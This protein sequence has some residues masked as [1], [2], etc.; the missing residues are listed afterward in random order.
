M[1][2]ARG[3]RI[4]EGS[5]GNPYFGSP[6][7]SVVWQQRPANLEAAFLCCEHKGLPIHHDGFR[8]TVTCF[9]KPADEIKLSTLRRAHRC[10]LQAIDFAQ[11]V[12]IT[13]SRRSGSPPRPPV[14]RLND[15]LVPGR[16][17]SSGP[18]GGTSLGEARA[19]FLMISPARRALHFVPG[20]PYEALRPG[21]A[22]HE[23]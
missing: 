13:F 18:Q 21:S 10:A 9:G 19:P 20:R 14:H 16:A 2:M 4:L 3:P 8:L 12:S 23:L 17:G 6:I 22:L 1:S 7:K 15:T 5:C 11:R